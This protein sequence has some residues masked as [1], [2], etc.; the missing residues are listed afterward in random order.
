MYTLAQ[1][2]DHLDP[3]GQQSL[4]G[5]LKGLRDRNVF[6]PSEETRGRGGAQVFTPLDAC[7]IAVIA[8]LHDIDVGD[9]KFLGKQVWPKLREPDE[10]GNPPIAHIM[11]WLEDR[12]RY[13]TGGGL[14]A[15][16]IRLIFDP[17]THKV[18]KTVDYAS[19]DKGPRP[20]PKG[21]QVVATLSLDLSV[22]LQRFTREGE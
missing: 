6:P 4:Q 11:H 22:V 19:A 21:C 10:D 2:A 13:P 16:L 1:I 3:T 18:W 14:P 20:I 17:S 15:L 8:A 12:K 9:V 5:K 7:A